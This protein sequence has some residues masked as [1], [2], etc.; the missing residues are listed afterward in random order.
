MSKRIA[1][2]FS[3]SGHLLIYHLGVAKRLSDSA[4]APRITAYAGASGGAIAAA[5]C[6]LLP[7]SDLETFVQDCALRCDGFGGLARALGVQSQ[8]VINPQQTGGAPQV[9]S[10][11]AVKQASGSLFVGATHCR[12]GRQALF[13]KYGS[14]AE[15]MR[16]ILASAAI[17]RSAH[18][19]DL[20]RGPRRPPTYPES[21]GIIVPPRCEW[22]H[23]GSVAEPV[24]G[25]GLPFSPHGEAYVDGGLTAAVPLP[26][27]ELQLA[28]ITVAPIS[29]PRGRLHEYEHLH[30]CPADASLKVPV[31]AP[32]LAGMRCF[33]SVDNLVAA[34]RSMG[35]SV[36]S[37]QRYYE[38]GQADAEWLVQQHGESWP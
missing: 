30:V 10:D 23:T 20:L 31:V 3:G 29:G 2:S 35:A 25:D 6:A 21:E 33:L 7:P 22:G 8:P 5:A 38:R 12:T 17:P 13:A 27:P 36:P 28:T 9:I 34:R 32:A 18:P 26:P 15:L 16:C 4:W 19:F 1:L 37:L 14:G 11:E 24:E